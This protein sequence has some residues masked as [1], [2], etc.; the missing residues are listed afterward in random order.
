MTTA[1]VGRLSRA[2]VLALRGLR[3]PGLALKRLR[4]TGIF[5]DPSIS[6]QHQTSAQR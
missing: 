1:S 5:C 4:Q 3:L 6:I 2:Q